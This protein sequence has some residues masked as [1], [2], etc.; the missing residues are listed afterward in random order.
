MGKTRQDDDDYDDYDDD[1]GGGG[2]CVNTKPHEQPNE[3]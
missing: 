1:Y 2:G 3:T